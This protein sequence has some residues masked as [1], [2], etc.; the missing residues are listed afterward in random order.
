VAAAGRRGCYGRAGGGR[1]SGHMNGIRPRVVDRWPRAGRWRSCFGLL[2][3]SAL[4]LL[5]IAARAVLLLPAAATI[6]AT[7]AVLGVV[8]VGSPPPPPPP[9]FNLEG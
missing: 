7:T 6:A 4:L 1:A 9:E 5:L 3:R 2:L 8:P